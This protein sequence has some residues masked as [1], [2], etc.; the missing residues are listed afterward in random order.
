MS[1][2]VP[3]R[4]TRLGEYASGQNH[5][6]EMLSLPQFQAPE[7]E[8]FS[9]L[10]TIMRAYSLSR[11]KLARK[12]DSELSARAGKVI[13]PHHNDQELDSGR[14]MKGIKNDSRES[15]NRD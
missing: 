10:E 6:S 2:L 1:F 13:E 12:H 3:V 11:V 9:E 7:S 4:E 5:L 15:R 8:Y 14:T